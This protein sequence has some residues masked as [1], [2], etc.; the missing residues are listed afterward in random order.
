MQVRFRSFEQFSDECGKI[1]LFW[2]L[3]VSI[4]LFN[5]F[6][7]NSL[8]TVRK[9]SHSQP[10]SFIKTLLLLFSKF[11]HFQYRVKKILWQCKT[12]KKEYYNICYIHTSRL[13]FRLW[14]SVQPLQ[15]KATFYIF[16]F[17]CR[18]VT[19]S[20]T[21]LYISIKTFLAFNVRTFKCKSNES[22]SYFST[23]KTTHQTVKGHHRKSTQSE[24]F[25]C[26]LS[27]AESPL[28]RWRCL[29]RWWCQ[30]W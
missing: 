10:V 24:T 28:E 2:I 29:H 17:C 4:K 9:G 19:F 22:S 8:T 27:S 5:E 7:S 12:R 11:T 18:S 21:D 25:L 23:L 30:L 6:V 3:N 1:V 20:L 13:N 16:F 26:C 15:F 14:A